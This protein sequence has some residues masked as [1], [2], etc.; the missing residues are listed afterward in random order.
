MPMGLP[1]G[2]A[3]VATARNVML[4]VHYDN[5]DKVQIRDSSGFKLYYTDTLRANDAMI[6]TLG[7]LNINI[8]AGATSHQH[9]NDCAAACTNKL[10]KPLTALW[11]GLHMHSAGKAIWTDHYRGEQQL[12]PLG[13]KHSWDFNQQSPTHVKAV[14]QP[15]DRLVTHCVYNAQTRGKAT[16]FGEGT[17]DEMCFNFLMVYPADGVSM[18]MD[19]GKVS[20]KADAPKLGICLDGKIAGLPS[21]FGALGRQNLDIAAISQIAMPFGAEPISSAPYSSPACARRSPGVDGKASSGAGMVPGRSA[22]LLTVPV[23]AFLWSTF[24]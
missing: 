18:C 9:T 11:A 3:D 20:S 21:L 7:H 1:L 17:G 23:L 2:T 4:E 19:I 10:K 22:M 12:A 8:P 15:G 5:P 13:Q 24:C 16:R 6:M 14:I